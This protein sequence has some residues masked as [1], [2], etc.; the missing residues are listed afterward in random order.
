MHMYE[1]NMTEIWTKKPVINRKRIYDNEFQDVDCQ[2]T[3]QL[4][5]SVKLS[6]V[7]RL[8]NH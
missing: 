6:I 7:R 3:E 8:A 4:S 1:I 5:M 2:L